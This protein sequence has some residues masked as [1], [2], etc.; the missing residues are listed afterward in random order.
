MDQLNIAILGIGIVGSRVRDRLILAGHRVTCWSRTYR[1]LEGEKRTA[2]EAVAGADLVGIFV[3]DAPMLREVMTEVTSTLS[4]GVLV[5]NHATVDLPSTLWLAGECAA[6]GCEFLDTPFTGSKDAAAAGQLLF[7]VGGS[8]ALMEK[9]KGY[10]AAISKG[11]MHCGEVGTATVTK[12]ATN[13]ISASTVQAMSEALVIA[14][15]HGVKPE[16]F[17]E[18]AMRNASG[19][20]LMAMKYT[21]ILKGDFEPHFTLSNMWKDSRYALALAESAGVK[22][23][24]ISVVSERMGELC[25]QGMGDLDYSALAKAYE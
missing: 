21:G 22:L 12:L 17:T 1:G 7:Y 19:S 25:E 20:P 24:G 10:F 4:E 16:V 2:S 3:K 9:V 5:M 13:L 18:A 11:W 23:P 8:E 14:K 6:R 15:K